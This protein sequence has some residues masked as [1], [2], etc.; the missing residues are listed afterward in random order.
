MKLDYSKLN[1][2]LPAIIQEAATGLVLMIGFMNEE[3]V[4]RTLDTGVVTFFSRSRNKIWIKGETSGHRLL[5]REVATDCDQDAL[6]VKVEALGPGVCHNGYRSCF[7]R[8]RE[9]GCWIE[10]EAPSFDP[11]AVYGGGE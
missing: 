2:V 1:G 9:N 8:R 3:A 7:Y 11:A 6:L 4:Q 10:T 5:V